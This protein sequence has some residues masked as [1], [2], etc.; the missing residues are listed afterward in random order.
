[1]SSDIDKLRNTIICGDCLEVMKQWPEAFFDNLLIVTDPPF[2]KG[3]RYEGEFD[4]NRP[5]HDYWNWYQ[6]W[7]RKC[8]RI[9]QA[10][11]LYVSCS[12]NQ[13]WDARSRIEAAGWNYIQFIT[14]YGPN[15]VA[16]TARYNMPWSPLSE[17]ILLFRKGKRQPMMNPDKTSG[18]NTADVQIHT[19]PQ[20]N[21]A[22]DQH[23]VHVCQKPVALYK[24]IIGRT[25]GNP[26]L[27]PFTG[28]GT[29]PIAARELGRDYIGIEINP[30]YCNLAEKRLAQKVLF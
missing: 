30:E 21:F 22:G 6:R 16:G 14:W 8:Y 2:N 4:D 13:L 5:P 9:A 25:P 11:H 20:S 10:A 7:A 28:S 27:D 18:W 19:R 3:K 15:L 23:R 26:V 17:P 1:M 12:Q 29:I 24:P